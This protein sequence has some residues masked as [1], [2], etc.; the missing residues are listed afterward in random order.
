[1]FVGINVRT[2][3]FVS[4]GEISLKT[5]FHAV[6]VGLDIQITS[7]ELG[8]ISSFPGFWKITCFFF[9]AYLFFR[10]RERQSASRVGA[11][12]RTQNPKQT[13]GSGLSA[14]SPSQDSNTQTVRS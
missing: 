5:T 3:T 12:R 4:S 11:Q 14:Q 7:N 10:E 9:N 2:F 8:T 13:P 6:L 1:M